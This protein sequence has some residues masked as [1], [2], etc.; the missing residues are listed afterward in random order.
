MNHELVN[1]IKQLTNLKDSFILISHVSKDSEIM[2]IWARW[3]ITHRSIFS[4]KS[5]CLPSDHVF[6]GQLVTELIDKGC[7]K[8]HA[9]YLHDWLWSQTSKINKNFQL[10]A[11]TN[12]GGIHGDVEIYAKIRSNYQSADSVTLSCNELY[13]TLPKKIYHKLVKNIDK[14]TLKL[15]YQDNYIWLIS[16]LYG[17]LDGHGL[18]WAVPEKV[19][20]LLHNQLGCDTE[21]FASPINNYYRN[22]YSIF[23][24]DELFGSKGN[25][26]NA[27]DSD[28]K[29]GSFQVNPPFIDSLF[30]KTTQKILRWLS[31]ADSNNEDL[32]F[33][34]IMPKW[35]EFVTYN[36]VVESPYC[37]KN[38]D[39]HADR[40]YYYAYTNDTYIKARFGTSVIIL[41][42]DNNIG[43]CRIEK[44]IIKSFQNPKW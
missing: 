10:V 18:Q 21:L 41:S 12:K 19:M 23:Q 11:D 27:P 7:P 4:Q 20:V 24:Y 35:Q 43:K 9:Y 8:G 38:I 30:T 39:L 28:F 15:K 34:Y 29:S 6:D 5:L 17:L 1:Y 36:M 31:I 14:D 32:T 26:F 3:I 25:F 44:D 42:T 37:I 2:K 16:T 40:H 33:V 22:Y 13:T